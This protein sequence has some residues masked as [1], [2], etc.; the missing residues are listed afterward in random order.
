M[1]GLSIFNKVVSRQFLAI[2]NYTLLGFTFLSIGLMQYFRYNFRI[3]QDECDD[4]IDTPS[5]YAVILRR[6]P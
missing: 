2:Q 4:T 6:L 5:D 1:D 3:I